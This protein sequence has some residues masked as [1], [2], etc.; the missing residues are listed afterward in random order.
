MTKRYRITVHMTGDG[1][2]YDIEHE[3]DQVLL[4]IGHSLYFGDAEA[5]KEWEPYKEIWPEL[6]EIEENEDGAPGFEVLL[7]FDDDPDRWPGRMAFWTDAMHLDQPGIGHSAD[8]FPGGS[9]LFR[10]QGEENLDGLMKVFKEK[11]EFVE[12]EAWV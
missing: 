12:G 6:M 1:D 2:E 5:K 7:Y 10:I 3:A 11:Y 9:E 4:D 8:G